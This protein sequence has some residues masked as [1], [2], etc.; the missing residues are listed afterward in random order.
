MSDVVRCLLC[1]HG[2]DA[3]GTDVGRESCGAGAASGRLCDCGWSREDVAAAHELIQTRR[4]ARGRGYSL[5]LDLAAAPG[6]LG[7]RW[8]VCGQIVGFLDVTLV[9]DAVTCAGCRYPELRPPVHIT[10]PRCGMTSSNPNDVR[11]GYCGNC[12]DW[13]GSAR[14]ITGASGAADPTPGGQSDHDA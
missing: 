9:G 5:H 1:G 3:H 6:R 8:T 12:H 10:C 13:T 11:E 7:R 2:I 4:R 14:V